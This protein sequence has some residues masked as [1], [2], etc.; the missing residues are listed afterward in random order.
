MMGI[1]V[2]II[3]IVLAFGLLMAIINKKMSN[4]GNPAASSALADFQNQDKRNAMETVIEMKAGEK[5]FGQTN[6]EKE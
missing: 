1:F 4:T 2:W 3:L 5:Q 6:G